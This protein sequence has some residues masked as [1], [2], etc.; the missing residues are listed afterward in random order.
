M[1]NIIKSINK[2]IEKQ[3][4]IKNILIANRG[5]PAIKFIMSIREWSKINN[6]E[7]NLWGI[8]TELDM[9]SNYKYINNLDYHIFSE[10]SNVFMDMDEI[11]NICK[12]NKIESV[13]PGW[14]YLSEEH[15]FSKKLKENDIIFIGPSENSLRLLGDKI[16]CMTMAD[17]LNVPQLAWSK[18]ECFDINEIKHHSEN[19][20]LPVILKS[21]NGGG[22]KGIRPLFKID[23]LEETI[24]Q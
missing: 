2:I 14:G 12:N 5:L 20:G 11:I 6:L 3:K 4:V 8:V 23:D 15:E 21:S 19:I 18:K 16:E 22:G 9:I 10:N 24:N 7:I 13:W 17:K 1:G